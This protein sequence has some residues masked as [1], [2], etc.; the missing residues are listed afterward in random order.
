MTL[1]RRLLFT[2]AL[3]SL[4]VAVALYAGVQWLRTRDLTTALQRFATA[5][6]NDGVRADCEGYPQWFLAGPRDPRPK[7]EDRAKPDA[8]VYLPRPS[9]D[10]LPFEYFAYDDELTADSTASPRFP[11]ELKSALRSG[12][13]S[14]VAPFVTPEG[15]GLQMAIDTGWKSPCAVLLVRLR[16]G[17]RQSSEHAM[18]F[19]ALY[20]TVFAAALLISAETE[21]RIRRVSTAARA[22]AR[23]EVLV[24]GA[25]QG[26][27]RNWIHGGHVQRG[28]RRHPAPGGRHQR[29]R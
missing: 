20:L 26:P 1:R 29:P 4:P 7:P 8:D 17:P 11:A 15:T 10:P 28:R 24:V 6:I 2:S 19:G 21:W 5:Q 25:G 14:I 3:V 18:L 22:S 9:A 16:P 27:R 12:S 13:S 23:A